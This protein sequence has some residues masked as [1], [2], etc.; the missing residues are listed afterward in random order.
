MCAASNKQDGLH[1]E[2]SQ[3]VRLFKKQLDEFLKQEVEPLE[4]EYEQFLGEFGERNRVDD[5][6]RLVDEY[7]EVR[8]TIQRRSHEAGF[9][10]MYMPEEYGGGGLSNLEFTQVI[11]HLH[12]RN[13]D[14]FHELILDTLSVRPAVIPMAHDDYQREKYFDPIMAADKHLAFGLTEPDHGSDVTWMDTTAEKDGDEWVIDGA[15]C[16]TTNAP[17]ADF[18][19]V[20]ARTSGDDGDARGISSFIVDADNPGWEVG[21][22]Q[23]P[24]GTQV[25]EQSFNHFTNCRVPDSHVVGEEGEALIDAMSWVN[26]ARIR[27]PAE[28][29]GRCQWMV[30][31]CI[32]YAKDRK[33]F[34]EPIGERQF[35]QGHLADM[36]AD[37]EMVRWLYRY[38]AWEIDRDNDPRW[39]LSAAKLRGAELWW[40]VADRAVQIHGGAGYMRSL[41]FESELRTARAA[42]IYDGTDEV[43]R[44][45]IARDLLNL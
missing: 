25:G 6:G 1:F 14:G 9:Y 44:R 23:P 38:A 30:E 2:P 28:A 15:K 39:L 45:T 41:P 29:V 3:Q 22:I 10:T 36:R 21:K 12:N 37:I 32:E 20:Y 18:I 26:A 42:R 17:Y 19:T 24:M 33:T 35:V 43:Q 34:G 11:E 4:D 27:L 16:F 40:D 5:D 8:E 13:P 7:L 31:Q